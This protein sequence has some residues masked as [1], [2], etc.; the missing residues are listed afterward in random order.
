MIVPV[1]APRL[2]QLRFSRGP[3]ARACARKG[4]ATVSEPD[5]DDV[6]RVLE[7]IDRRIYLDGEGFRIASDPFEVED[8]RTRQERLRA[9]ETYVALSKPQQPPIAEP[10]AAMTR[11]PDSQNST[12]VDALYEPSPSQLAAFGEFLNSISRLSPA[13]RAIAAQ[14]AREDAEAADRREVE[15]KERE[16]AEAND[17]RAARKRATVIKR[18][19]KQT[20][21]TVTSF[22]LAADGSVTSVTFAPPSEAPSSLTADD[23]LARW[24]RQHAR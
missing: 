14:M 2:E 22:A 20:G 6:D 3:G 23:E 1:P 21:K 18:I 24:R 9:M 4:L 13:E 16:E 7:A 10:A 19:E 17:R 5:P 8:D 11:P 15:A 12:F